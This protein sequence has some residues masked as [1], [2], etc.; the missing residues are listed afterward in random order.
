MSAAVR[1]GTRVAKPAPTPDETARRSAIARRAS[2]RRKARALAR[3]G[4]EDFLAAQLAAVLTDLDDA[5]IDGSWPAVAALHRRALDMREEI[6]ALPPPPEE[7]SAME[8]HDDAALMAIVVSALPGLPADLLD[9][10]SDAIAAVRADRV[11]PP[12]PSE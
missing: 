4:R 10:L 11:P 3:L 2:G 6:D 9:H 7:P 5:R 12:I 8:Q 1:Y